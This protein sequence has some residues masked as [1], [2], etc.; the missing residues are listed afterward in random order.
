VA[1]KDGFL[2]A[3]IKTGNIKFIDPK[4]NGLNYT[5]FEGEWN[6]RP[7]LD[8]IKAVSTGK[9]YDFDVSRIKKREDYIVI[10]FEGF[11]LN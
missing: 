2:P 10:I 11:Y 1:Y 6:E 9:Q 8:E 4:I 5:V 3:Y 7:D